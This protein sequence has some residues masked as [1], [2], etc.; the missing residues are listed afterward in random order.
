MSYLVTGA[1]GFIGRHLVARLLDRD[2]DVY[3]LV[4][5]GSLDKLASLHERWPAGSEDHVHPVIGDLA[6]P[7]LGVSD[8]D[9]ARLKDVG[10][11]HFF[12]L[13]AIYDMTVDDDRNRV[14][15]VEGTRHAVELANAIGAGTFHHASSIAVAGTYQ[16]LFREDMFD[17]GQKLPH[18]Y[19]RTKFEAEKIARSQ[20]QMPWR[21]HRPRS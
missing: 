1:T 4:R 15:N 21:V 12:H 20:T 8:E 14:A 3:V 10:V 13:A 18:A 2:D 7:R 5:Q 17:E 11:G 9:L 19:H 6:R 16:G